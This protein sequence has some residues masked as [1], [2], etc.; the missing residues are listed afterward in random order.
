MNYEI[1]E[2]NPEIIKAMNERLAE[3]KKETVPFHDWMDDSFQY[4]EKR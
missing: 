2:V 4:V 1:L 3:P